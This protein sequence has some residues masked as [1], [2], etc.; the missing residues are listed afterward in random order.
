MMQ[1]AGGMMLYPA[2]SACFVGLCCCLFLGFFGISA[3]Q[4]Y[5]VQEL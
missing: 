3:I 5:G 2:Y 4:E 1:Q